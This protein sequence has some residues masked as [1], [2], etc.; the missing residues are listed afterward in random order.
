MEVIRDPEVP[1]VNLPPVP[2]ETGASTNSLLYIATSLDAWG[3][4]AA[5]PW[6]K[7]KKFIVTYEDC[8]RR[9]ILQTVNPIAHRVATPTDGRERYVVDLTIYIV[10]VSLVG[11]YSVGASVE[12][13]E[14]LPATVALAT[15]LPKNPGPPEKSKWRA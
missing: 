15:G 11:I 1:M 4:Q 7:T 9:E 10:G 8:K 14:R 2:K 5:H 3:N 13:L 12:V 6:A